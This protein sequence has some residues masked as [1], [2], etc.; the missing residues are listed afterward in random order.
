MPPAGWTSPSQGREADPPPGRDDHHPQ[1]EGNGAGEPGTHR[2]RAAV[3]LGHIA[4]GDQVVDEHVHGG[5]RQ[6]HHLDAERNVEV[7]GRRL[8]AEQQQP[9]RRRGGKRGP[10]PRQRAAVELR[11]RTIPAPDAQ[12]AQIHHRDG[13]H[14]DR[15][16]QYVQRLKEREQPGRLGDRHRER[17]VL[18]R[19]HQIDQGH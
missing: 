3:P 5:E 1:R 17:L 12:Q 9:E 18:Q 8:R 2:C 4:L 10:G 7:V 15:Q 14:D 19:M 13:A 11:D 16:K 6:A